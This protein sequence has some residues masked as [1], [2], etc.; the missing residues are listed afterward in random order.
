MG[1]RLY[2]DGGI[3]QSRRPDD[4]LDD[5]SPALFQFIGAG[6]CGNVD[7]LIDLIFKLFKGERPVIEGGGQTESKF[8]QG[9]LA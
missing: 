4:L 2:G 3:H 8:H 5:L 7:D 6:G 9:F 1:C